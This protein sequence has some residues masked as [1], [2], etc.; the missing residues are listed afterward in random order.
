MTCG[1][2]FGLDYSVFILEWPGDFSVALGADDL[3]LCRRPLKL[4]SK[5][6]VGLVTVGAQDHASYYL[7]TEGRGE[8]G[9][10]IL[11]ALKAEV[12]LRNGKEMPGFVR[13]MHAVAANT[14]HIALAMSCALIDHVLARVA[15][16]ATVVYL[17]GSGVRRVEDL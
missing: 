15:L 9:S 10:L 3:L 8:L 11:M 14:A 17:L 4:L 13:G 12:W 5:A 7:V 6:A 1:T 16:Q 2:T